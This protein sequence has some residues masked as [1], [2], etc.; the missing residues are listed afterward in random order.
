MYL[1]IYLNTCFLGFHQNTKTFWAKIF[2]IYISK[3]TPSFGWKDA[4]NSNLCA[5]RCHKLRL[6]RLYIPAELR[7]GSVPRQQGRLQNM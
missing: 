4:E 2:I 7:A 1:F 5:F 3:K 6:D